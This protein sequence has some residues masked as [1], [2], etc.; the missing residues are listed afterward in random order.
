MVA[1]LRRRE[2]GLTSLYEK[3]D[4]T[5]PAAGWSSTSSSRSRSNTP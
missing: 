3:L 2:I 1:E 4:I 5:T